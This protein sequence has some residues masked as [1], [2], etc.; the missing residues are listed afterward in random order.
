MY[1]QLYLHGHITFKAFLTVGENLSSASSEQVFLQITIKEV[2]NHMAKWHLYNKVSTVTFEFF[3]ISCVMKPCVNK[4]KSIKTKSR[5]H[6][7]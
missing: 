6:V 3:K 5:G 2:K 7:T 1:T 4:C